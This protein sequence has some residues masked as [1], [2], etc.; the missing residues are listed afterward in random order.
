MFAGHQYPQF[1]TA[2]C[3]ENQNLLEQDSSKD[4]L[5]DDL[6]CMVASGCIKVYAFVLMPDHVHYLWH[7]H[8]SLD[9]SKIKEAHLFNVAQKIRQDLQANRQEDFWE[10]NTR[11]VDLYTPKAIYQK[12][13]FIHANPERERWKLRQDAKAY[14]FSSIEFYDTGYDRFNFLTHV[15]ERGIWNKEPDRVRMN[16]DLLD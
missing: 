7:V 11:S 10:I 15:G 2:S 16:F 1:F 12:L 8:P 5:L 3:T 14:P 4:L 6:R 9:Y 13:E